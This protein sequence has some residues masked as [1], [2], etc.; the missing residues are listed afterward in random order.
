M[1]GTEILKSVRVRELGGVLGNF[2]LDRSVG[3]NVLGFASVRD[4]ER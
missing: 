2:P 4:R 3:E 1:L